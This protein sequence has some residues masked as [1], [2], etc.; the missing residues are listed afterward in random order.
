M[1]YPAGIR[2]SR[3]LLCHDEVHQIIDAGLRF[4]ALNRDRDFLGCLWSQVDR[5]L[6][7]FDDFVVGLDRIA[8]HVVLQACEIEAVCHFEYAFC[9]IYS[10]E[11]D[12]LV[13][14]F[15]FFHR[16]MRRAVRVDDTVAKEVTVA[17]HVFAE[18]ASVSII[19]FSVFILDEQALVHP[20]PDIAAPGG[21]GICR[22]LSTGPKGYRSSYPIAWAYSDGATGRSLPSL[23]ISSSHFALG[24]C[25]TYMSEFHSHCARS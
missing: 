9:R 20:V 18:V 1:S 21:S 15:H 13:C 22:S 3:W 17:R 16:R 8:D 5:H 19:F 12:I 7:A 25:G 14:I 11:T 2:P 23:P 10:F 24:Y 6:V 4:Q